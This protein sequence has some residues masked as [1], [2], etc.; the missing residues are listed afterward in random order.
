MTHVFQLRDVLRIYQ[1][2]RTGVVLDVERALTE[3]YTPWRTALRSWLRNSARTYLTFTPQNGWH[4][5]QLV[6]RH[7]RPEWDI[8]FLAPAPSSDREDPTPWR[9]LLSRALRDALHRGTYRI[10]ATL[11]ATPPLAS[12]FQGSGFRPYARERLYRYLPRDPEPPVPPPGPLRRRTSAHAW[13][14]NRLWHQVTPPLVSAAETLTTNGL[15]IPYAWGERP[16]Q[17][18]YIWQEGETVWA[19]IAL[20]WGKRAHW[21]RVLA[22]QNAGERLHHLLRW[23][24][25]HLTHKLRRP[26]YATV[27]EYQIEEQKALSE[28]DFELHSEHTLLVKHLALPLNADERVPEGILALAGLGGKPVYSQ[29]WQEEKVI[30][31]PAQPFP[32]PPT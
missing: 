27:R 5:L 17:H 14:F 16:G 22:A 25:H 20:K 29:S 13:G 9:D 24:I 7:E 26:I 10:Y 8:V 31:H 21:I 28:L 6:R 23:A 12:V 3:G 30:V 11:T 4:A 32:P 19:A 18:V 15:N 1:L 2:H